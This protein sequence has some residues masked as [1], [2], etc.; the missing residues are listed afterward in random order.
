MF[1]AQTETPVNDTDAPLR[2]SDDRPLAVRGAVQYLAPSKARPRILINEN[3]TRDE[4]EIENETHI[5]EVKNARKLDETFSLDGNGFQLIEHN[6]RVHD[7]FNENEVKEVLYPE[8][9]ALLKKHAGAKDVVIFDATIRVE[10]DEE[11][12]KRKPVRR[13]H[14][15]YTVKSGPQRVRDLV[16]AEEQDKWLNGRFAIVNL[17]RAIGHNVERS[18]LA[19]ADGKTTWSEDFVAID[20]VYPDRVGEIYGVTASAAHKWYYYPN[21]TTEEALLIKTYDSAEDGPVR[22]VAHASFEDPSSPE[23]A[24]P[25]QSIELRALVRLG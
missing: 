4:Q 1:D 14:S 2:S 22:F 19:F 6:S 15:D 11:T 13:I 3:G 10:S 17:W 8:A 9:E 25:R 5:V 24:K 16:P 23:N 18:P 7:F 21:M 20:L 12:G